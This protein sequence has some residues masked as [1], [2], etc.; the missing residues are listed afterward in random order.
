MCL[1]C[2]GISIKKEKIICS[3][4]ITAIKNIKNC[5][6]LICNNCPSL[7]MIQDIQNLVWLECRKCISLKVLPPIP[8]LTK[9]DCSGCT[10]LES[11]PLLE[12]LTTLNCSGCTM[13]ESIPELPMLTRLRCMSCINL[14]RISHLKSVEYI[15]CINCSMLTIVESTPKTFYYRGCHWLN[16]NN[17]NQLIVTQRYYKKWSKYKILKRWLNSSEFNE[18]YYSPGN[19]GSI[20]ALQHLEKVVQKY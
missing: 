13:L 5:R 14:K 1:F 12:S 15:D 11:I 9:L 18:W 19:R 16:K 7:N 20:K 2:T 4:F 3:V 8:T 17:V 6:K 10:M